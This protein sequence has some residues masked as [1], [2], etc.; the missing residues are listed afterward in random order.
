MKK[1]FFIFEFGIPNYRDFILDALNL[2]F[3]HEISGVCAD[4]KFRHEHP[5]NVIKKMKCF[6]ESGENKL[7]F[8]SPYNLLKS[9][10]IISTFNLRR[11]HTWIY[12]LFFP[13]KTWIFWG[14]GLW[15]NSGFFVSVIR[16]LLLK[17][18][19]GY[20]VYTEEGKSN[21]IAFG[22]PE[23]KISVA[24]NTLFV[25]NSNLS[26]GGK[27]LLYFGRLQSRKKLHLIF[28]YLKKFNFHLRIVGDGEYK[29][30]LLKYVRQYRVEDYV[31]FFPGTFDLDEIKLHF[32]NALCYVSP[33]HV[34]LGVVQSFAFG[35]PVF[36]ISSMNH[37]PEFSYC[38]DS[39]SYLA[40]SIPCVY[41]VLKDLKNDSSLLIT[42]KKAAFA[43]FQNN[44][45]T[46]NVIDAF[47]YHINQ[48]K[49]KK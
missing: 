17:I 42:R 5:D 9:D 45:S 38:N 29:S 39:N 34:G 46:E 33:G 37:A 32:D 27:Y 36:T 1:I 41:E 35:C 3:N 16:K 12:T 14:Q 22:Y 7:Y 13:W 25:P 21:L 10:L 2:R 11:P 47:N 43:Y 24:N 44:L 49:G 28:P 8:F 4:D 48:T 23:S 15:N 18:S 26:Y 6:Y 19:S 20:I 30:V 31:E 40:L